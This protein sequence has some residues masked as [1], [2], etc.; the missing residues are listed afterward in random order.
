MARRSV[1]AVHTAHGECRSL[2]DARTQ[3][4]SNIGE[5]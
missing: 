3:Q 4:R 5:R 1:L 2:I